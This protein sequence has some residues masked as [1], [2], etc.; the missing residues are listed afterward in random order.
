LYLGRV[1]SNQNKGIVRYAG[2]VCS[3]LLLTA[4]FPN[5][6]SPLI[7]WFALVPL[8]AV[9]GSCSLL[10]SLRW[11]YLCG[12]IHFITLIYWIIPCLKT[13]GLLPLYLSIIIL[14]VF[15]GI[16]GPLHCRL[17]RGGELGLQGCQNAAIHC[18]GFLGLRSNMSGRICSPVFP[19][20]SWGIPSIRVLPLIQVADVLGVYGVSFLVVMGNTVVFLIYLSLSGQP[21]ERAHTA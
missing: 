13:Y 5:L 1:E 12:I 19:G 20:N 10:D 8:M 3:G 7:A 18:P 4:S 9:L 16:P 15:C 17:C 2:V 21:M 6:G 14:I 11:G